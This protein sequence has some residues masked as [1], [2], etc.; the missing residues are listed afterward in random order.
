[1]MGHGF[2]D[3]GPLYG[4]AGGFL[5]QA[6]IDAPLS[7][8]QSVRQRRDQ[9]L[10]DLKASSP[11]GMSMRSELSRDAD[12]MAS[13]IADGERKV[14]SSLGHAFTEFGRMTVGKRAL[15][16]LR[17]MGL[18][19]DGFSFGTKALGGFTAATLLAQ[20]ASTALGSQI[21][22]VREEAINSGKTFDQ[23]AGERGLW[24]GM[25]RH[26][27]GAALGAET[28]YQKGVLGSLAWGFGHLANFTNWATGSD[29][30]VS[31]IADDAR[32]EEESRRH[33]KHDYEAQGGVDALLS[34]YRQLAMGSEAASRYEWLT[35]FQP[36]Q[37]QI[38]KWDS[39]TAA[40][41]RLD[42][43]ASATAHEK[44]TLNAWEDA[45]NG[46]GARQERDYR[47][48]RQAA[49]AW[50]G[51]T[52]RNIDTM[53]QRR[54]E[55]DALG[56]ANALAIGTQSE[57]PEQRYG[58]SMQDIELWRSYHN[59]R[60]EDERTYQS[61]RRTAT[62]SYFRDAMG[63]DAKAIRDRIAGPQGQYE[64][65]QTNLYQ[66]GAD[67]GLTPDEVKRGGNLR[68]EDERKRLGVS[69]PLG[70]YA[71]D[72]AEH[73]RAVENRTITPDEFAGWQK[74]RRQSALGEMIAD[75]PSVAPTAAMASGSDAAH[76][77][78][79]GAMVGDPKTAAAGG[80]DKALDATNKL[81]GQ[82]NVTLEQVLVAIQALAF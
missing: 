76:A 41:K 24:N 71:R 36:S 45:V 81:L 59:R 47:A 51:D 74:K 16:P 19:V 26:T 4:K 52:E 39:L 48:N 22:Q 18:A 58:K 34:R 79:T 69:N 11:F 44:S 17:E 30:R 37:E 29:A 8:L 28:G 40:I 57:T 20:H 7:K 3:A 66:H 82:Q 13:T 35:R 75:E 33:Q 72:V 32:N 38:G 70:D 50:P 80:A 65:E 2:T 1:M 27:E 31:S 77:V 61:M 49:G 62:Q 42:A 63:L 10:R 60:M 54:S 15:A 14:G 56:R 5:D 25:S 23:L 64:R 46:P 12:I 78:I 9:M 67:V 21:R 53:R 68:A 43:A 55:T 6:S 73:R